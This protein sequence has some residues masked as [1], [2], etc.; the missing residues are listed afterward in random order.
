MYT[1]PNKP[2]LDF[3]DANFWINTEEDSEMLNSRVQAI[4]S[5]ISD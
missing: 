4:G 3:T 5:Q 1:A 2:M